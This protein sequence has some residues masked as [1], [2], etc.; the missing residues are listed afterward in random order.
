MALS[1]I[2]RSE[3]EKAIEECDRLGRDLFLQRYGFRRARRYLL[4]HEGR[5]YDS[6]AVV[7]AAH[8]FL[9]GRA[10]EALREILLRVAAERHDAVR[11]A[12]R[13]PSSASP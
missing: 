6:K 8:G 7:G 3:V 2:T 10:R 5:Q 4:S 1:D 9:P 13:E 11:D 12:T